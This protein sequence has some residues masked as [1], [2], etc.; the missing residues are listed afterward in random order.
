MTV[1]CCANVAG[2]AL[3]SAMIFTRVNFKDY[4]LEGNPAST[5]G[6]ATAWMNAELVPRVL[7]H[8]I[9]HIGFF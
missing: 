1:C 6:L 2:Q 3:P 9:N 4:M 7:A 8:F 5:L